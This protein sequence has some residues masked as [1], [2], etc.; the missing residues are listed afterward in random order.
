MNQTEYISVSSIGDYLICPRRLWLKVKYAPR[1]SKS[2]HMIKGELLHKLMDIINK[3]V[4]ST[5]PDKYLAV[6]EK[7]MAFIKPYIELLELDTDFIQNHV[8]SSVMKDI[9]LKSAGVNVVTEDP[10]TSHT[11]KI[12][13]K[14]DRLEIFKEHIYLWEYK[15]GKAKSYI[16]R[17]YM[18]QVALY[19]MLAEEKYKLPVKKVFITFIDQHHTKTIPVI[20]TE[21]LK[22]AALELINNIRVLLRQPE[23]PPAKFSLKCRFCPEEIVRLCPIWVTSENIPT[24]SKNP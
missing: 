9:G 4:T 16:N 22:R 20:I 17:Y 23:M 6:I 11:Y 2:L 14:F 12:T 10:F 7:A 21:E 24:N 8:W 13:S 15:T 19:S 1:I 18:Y 5:T 3:E